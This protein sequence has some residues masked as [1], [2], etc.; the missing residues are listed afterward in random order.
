MQ[1]E[2]QEKWEE[3][4]DIYFQGKCNIHF[5]NLLYFA[6][7]KTETC[8]FRAEKEKYVAQDLGESR[9]QGFRTKKILNDTTN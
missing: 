4:L 6:Q 8:N 3:S 7:S 5:G 1:L 9:N 2:Q